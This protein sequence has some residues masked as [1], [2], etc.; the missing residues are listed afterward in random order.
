[1]R[2]VKEESPRNMEKDEGEEERDDTL[3]QVESA[4]IF[5]VTYVVDPR[6]LNACKRRCLQQ[7]L[8]SLMYILYLSTNASF[9]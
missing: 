6:Y 3:K 2:T 5:S 4:G 7:L 8:C 9:L 1:M